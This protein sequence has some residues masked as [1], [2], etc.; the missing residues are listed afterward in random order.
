[1][2]G[3]LRPHAQTASP[4]PVTLYALNP[5]NNESSSLDE[6]FRAHPHSAALP[7]I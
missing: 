1:M 3:Q 2:V 4:R 5:S 7:H 6:R